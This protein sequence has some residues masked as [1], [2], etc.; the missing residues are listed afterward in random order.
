[1]RETAPLFSVVTVCKDCKDKLLRTARSVHEQKFQNF[2]YI[3]KDGGSTDGT[4]DVFNE[5]QATK[6][7]SEPD[8][9]IFNAMNIALDYCSGEYVIFLNAGDTFCDAYVL[10]VIADD[11]SSKEN[12]DFLYGD[13]VS[14]SS[15]RKYI[16]HPVHPSRFYLYSNT[17]CH[18]VWFVKRSLYLR[19]GKFD[20]TKPIGG[21]YFFLLKSLIKEKVSF[22]HVNCFVANY[23]GSGVSTNKSVVKESEKERQKVREYLFCSIECILYDFLIKARGIVKKIAY[24]TFLFRVYRAHG[25]CR[26]KHKKYCRK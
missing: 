1:M 9:G 17:I 14:Y 12:V 23:E 26:Y 5:I 7:I 18:Q 6:I 8:S 21:D 4:V 11:L 25:L 2:E 22:R 20:D 3:I 10:S 13:V 15:R 24:D 19:L 16:I